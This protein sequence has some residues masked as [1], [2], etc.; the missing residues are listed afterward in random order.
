MARRRLRSN[1]LGVLAAI[2]LGLLWLPTFACSSDSDENAANGGSGGGPAC[3]SAPVPPGAAVCPTECTGGCDA[4]TCA[5][6]CVGLM[7]CDGDD[8]L[9]PPGF[10]CVVTCD[11]LDACDTGSVTCP[12]DYACQLICDGVDGCG[13]LTFE[14]GDGPCSIECRDTP[15]S[16][17]GAVVNCGGN[18]C[19]ATCTGTSSPELDCGSGCSCTVC[20]DTG[21]AGSGG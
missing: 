7:A 10:A 15:A 2:V 9:C 4:E 13:D 20:D 12:D 5:I 11:G 1:G 8:I 14:C 18:D 19:T 16:C 17:T 21:A 6:D 3:G